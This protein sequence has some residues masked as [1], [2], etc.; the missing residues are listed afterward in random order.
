[1][2]R[3]LREIVI[4]AF[5]FLFLSIWMHYKEWL[6]HPMEHLKALPESQF[7]PLHPLLFTFVLYLII[8]FLRLVIHWI[9]KL[10]RRTSA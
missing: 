7:G 9:R 5:L 3:V 4:F 1:M 2:K 10:Q 6:D 8:S